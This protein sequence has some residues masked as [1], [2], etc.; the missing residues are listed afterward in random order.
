MASAST[1]HHAAAAAAAAIATATPLGEI[2]LVI[3]Q[4]P[5]CS[6]PNMILCT[7]GERALVIENR[8]REDL[9]MHVRFRSG[10][11]WR[12]RARARSINTWLLPPASYST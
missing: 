6:T 10:D 8:I 4:T 5:L 3:E 2:A 7:T 1:Y 11:V 12:G 9:D